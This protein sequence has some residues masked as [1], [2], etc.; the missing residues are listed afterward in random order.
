MDELTRNIRELVIDSLFL[1]SS[2]DEQLAYQERVANA[3]V[4]A[5]LFC[6]WDGAFVPESEH[7]SKAFTAEELS[8]LNEFNDAFNLIS[9]KVPDELPAIEEFIK[10]KEWMELQTAAAKA[11]DKCQFKTPSKG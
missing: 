2:K 1:L 9:D 6:Q 3:D 5:E 7:N 4:S 10:T 11:W 8:Y